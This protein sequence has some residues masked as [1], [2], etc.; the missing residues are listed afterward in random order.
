[1][2]VVFVIPHHPIHR[3]MSGW[4]GLVRKEPGEGSGSSEERH[5]P[6]SVSQG[7]PVTAATTS[8]P[9]PSAGRWPDGSAP[10]A[11]T[12]PSSPL[13]AALSVVLSERVGKQ[14]VCVSPSPRSVREQR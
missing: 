11:A 6:C 9:T 4:E 13:S 10:G 3:E 1:M 7:R 14:A 8:L 12:S 5:L 2:V